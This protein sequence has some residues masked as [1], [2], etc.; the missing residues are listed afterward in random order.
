M[1]RVAGA[2]G[3][4]SGIDGMINMRL[5]LQRATTPTAC[6]RTLLNKEGTKVPRRMSRPAAGTTVRAASANDFMPSIMGMLICQKLL[7]RR[8]QTYGVT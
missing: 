5:F 8:K 2:D 3:G 1:L 6:Q 4:S 7:G